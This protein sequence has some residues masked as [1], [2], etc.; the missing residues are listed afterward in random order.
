MN[1]LFLMADEFRRD[2]AGFG[3]NRVTRTPCLDRLAGSGRVYTNAYTPSPV[4]VPAR[5]C[6]ATGTFP[7]RNGC[8]GFH[9][10]LPPGSPTFARWFAE[11]GY[12]TVA[13]GKLHH[14]GPDQ[15]QGWLHR[16]GSETA[17]RWPE[18]SGTRSQIGRL[19]WRGAEDVRAAGPGISPLGIHD[20]YTVQGACDFLRIHFRGDGMTPPDCPLLLMVSLQQ[21][22]FPL[23]CD[24]EL[25]EHYLPLVELPP[26]LDPPDH[27]LLARTALDLDGSEVLRARAAY[28]AMVEMTD[29]RFA[30]VLDALQACGENPD[31]WLIVFASDH[32]D[33][34][35]DHACWE[36]RS[37]YEQSAGIPLFIR[38]PGFLPGC[39]ERISNLVD[40]FPT[41]CEAAGL[42]TPE[43]L[44]GR[45]LRTPGS[46][47]LSQ[48]GTS[49]FMLRRGPWK[50]LNFGSEAPEVLFNLDT[51]PHETR[52]AS[53]SDEHS[54]ILEMMRARLREVLPAGRVA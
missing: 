51:D 28:A 44:D 8:E 19:S 4:C 30:A 38:G 41:L 43:G 26:H 35:G 16:I 11:H 25:F 27:P 22:H 12:Y 29:R 21:P 49:H 3:G 40:L 39:E 7:F 2:A 50:Y 18:K 34:L 1:I 47:T 53:R 20:D 54:D 31:D 17:V 32:G 24:Q 45:S 5:Q 23:L 13:C 37:F 48:L 6:L 10:D 14:R 15:M 9:T 33:M 36:K 46:E 52:D 42:P